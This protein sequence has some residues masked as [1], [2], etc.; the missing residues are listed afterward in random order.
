M[1]LNQL[2]PMLEDLNYPLSA[3]EL[4]AALDGET[5]VHPV[6][7]EPLSAVVKRTGPAALRSADDAWLS[8]LANVDEE[9][10]GRKHY[11]DRDPPCGPSETDAVSF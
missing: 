5:L 10:I 7:E 8:V 2:P 6:G 11:S 9:A 4:A 3:D 1:R